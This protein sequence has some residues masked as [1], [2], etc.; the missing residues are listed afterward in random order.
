VTEIEASTARDDTAAVIAQRARRR[1]SGGAERRGDAEQ[2][3]GGDADDQGE[4]EHP[5]VHGQVERDDRGAGGD[6][7]DQ[8]AAAPERQD[9]ARRGAEKRQQQALD[10]Q[11]ARD[12]PARR[13]ERETDGE[14]A[15]PRGGLR[16]QQVGHVAARHQQHERDDAEQHVERLA[17][18]R[19]Q[20][21]DAGGAG[22][23]RERLGEIVL[24]I[25]RPPVLRHRGLAPRRVEGGQPRVALF[26]GLAW[27]QPREHAQP[28]RAAL[29]ERALG[30]ADERL[31]AERH[32]DVEGAADLDAEEL[33]R[34]DADDCEGMAVERDRPSEHGGVAAVF[35]APERVAEHRDRPVLAAL[36][37]VVL[38]G[39]GP[40]DDRA[41]AQDVEEAA[42]REQAGDLARLAAGVQVEARRADGEDAAEEVLVIAQVFPLRVGERQARRQVGFGGRLLQDHEP[43]GLVQRQRLQ[44]QRVDE[45]EDGD[46]GADAEGQR[47]HGHGADGRGLAH[48]PEGKPEVAAEHVESAHGRIIRITS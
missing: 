2:Q 21:G 24:L 43:L 25:L 45:V 34:G 47:Q 42:A 33:R 4:A 9:D 48:Q 40:A 28:P 36:P 26:D 11:L 18:A 35:A 38:V 12:R 5:P 27:G 8:R 29:I 15:L 20:G 7:A 13:A 37:L 46:V 10:E 1:E 44:H 3:A 41:D 16:E 30:A 14:L 23:Q 6:Q 31:G 32:R 39:E 17:V 22:T 19:A